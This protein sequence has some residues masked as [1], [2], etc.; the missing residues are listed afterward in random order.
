MY[1]LNQRVKTLSIHPKHFGPELESIIKQNLVKELEGKFDREYGQT[2]IVRSLDHCSRGVLNTDT[3]YADFTIQVTTLDYVVKK[4]DICLAVVEEV[5]ANRVTAKS[6]C[7][8]IVIPTQCI[9][10]DF[11]FDSRS[12]IFRSSG[13]PQNEDA[14]D[15]NVVTIQKG[16]VLFTRI[17]G[18]PA[19]DQPE[20][21]IATIKGDY[22]G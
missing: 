15:S 3:Q 17:M 20:V 16:S 19:V 10:A 14:T 21:A 7:Y 1:C 6:G 13:K 5:N 8:V 18:F 12:N 22:L 11:V 4:S 9:D 2:V